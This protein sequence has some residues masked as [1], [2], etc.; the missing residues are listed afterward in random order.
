MGVF[1]GSGDRV[2]YLL[3]ITRGGKHEREVLTLV[4]NLQEVKKER[5]IFL[6]GLDFRE[7]IYAT[8]KR[9]CSNNRTLLF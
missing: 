6:N 9:N 8:Q 1:E 2:R 5:N 3:V 4:I 7:N